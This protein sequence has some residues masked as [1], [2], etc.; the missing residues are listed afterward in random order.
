MDANEIVE[1]EEIVESTAKNVS[2]KALKI[3][4]GVGV[5]ALVGVLTYKFVI[6][7]IVNKIKKKHQPVVEAEIVEEDDSDEEVE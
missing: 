4:V 1:N 5:T 2:A 6:K 7:P 3:G